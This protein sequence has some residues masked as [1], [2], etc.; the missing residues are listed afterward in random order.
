M[1]WPLRREDIWKM[2]KEKQAPK[3]GND[4][5]KETSSICPKLHCYVCSGDCLTT[6]RDE[7]R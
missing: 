7:G 2:K 3:Q 4:L 5:H 1:Q 6:R